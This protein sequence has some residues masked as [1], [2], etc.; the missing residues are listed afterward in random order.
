MMLAVKTT[1]VWFPNAFTPGADDNNTF[2]IHSA[3]NIVYFEMY[4]YNRQGN[5]VFHST[6]ANQPWNGLNSGG[7]ECMIGAYVY[8]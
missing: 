6:D 2:G 1:A 7:T 8:Y 3:A 5:L 4:I